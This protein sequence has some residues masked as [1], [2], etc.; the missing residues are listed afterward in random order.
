MYNEEKAK[1]I[2]KQSYI[3]YNYLYTYGAYLLRSNR[4]V[5]LRRLTRKQTSK[6]LP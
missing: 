4:L 5:Q 1:A 3:L 2:E 6:H